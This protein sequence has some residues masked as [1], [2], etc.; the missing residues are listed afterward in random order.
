[1]SDEARYSAYCSWC[2]VNGMEPAD[3]ETWIKI[4]KSILES[5]IGGSWFNL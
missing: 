1:M 4:Q 2:R 5:A 3:I